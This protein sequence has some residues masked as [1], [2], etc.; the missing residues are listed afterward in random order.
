MQLHLALRREQLESRGLASEDA[1]IAAARRFGNALRLKEESVDAWGWRWLEQFAQDLRFAC[2]T[3]IKAPGFT[4]IIVLTL[5][6]AA[7][8]RPPSSASSLAYCCDR[9]HLRIRTGWCK[10]MVA[11]GPKIAGSP[12]P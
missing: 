8:A 9:C 1:R 6:L 3:L 2:R 4:L 10:S 7:G 11:S 12:I 5:A